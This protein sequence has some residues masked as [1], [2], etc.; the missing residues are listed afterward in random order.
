M[1]QIEPIPIPFNTSDPLILQT[2]ESFPNSISSSVYEIPIQESEI[3]IEWTYQSKDFWILSNYQIVGHILTIQEDLIDVFLL[4][5]NIQ[6]QQ[7]QHHSLF[8]QNIAKYSPNNLKM[9]LWDLRMMRYANHE[10]L[11]KYAKVFLP[12]PIFEMNDK[13]ST[14]NFEFNE[15]I[16]GNLASFIENVWN[17]HRRQNRIVWNPHR[18]NRI[19]SILNQILNGLQ[20]LHSSNIIHGNL[21]PQHIYYTENGNC[22]IGN[23]RF[24]RIKLDH[25][26][27]G[28]YFDEDDFMGGYAPIEMLI[29]PYYS[30][31]SC[32]MW[33]VGCILAEL[34]LETKFDSFHNIIELIGPPSEEDLNEIKKLFSKKEQKKVKFISNAEIMN[35]MLSEVALENYHNSSPLAVDLMKK[36]L[37]Y[38]PKKRITCE[39]AL[40]HKYFKEFKSGKEEFIPEL[41][42]NDF[43]FNELNWKYLRTNQINEMIYNE[44]LLINYPD[45]LKNYQNKIENGKK[46]LDIIFDRPPNHLK[47]T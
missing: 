12:K 46:S 47:F 22:I 6:S 20:Y 1:G 18:Q 41:P 45:K 4:N 29:N 26:I 30:D 31:S 43:D 33:S 11:L 38:D 8:H 14:L 13:I 9:L 5:E 37:V 15:K 32:D 7:L 21:D 2:N 28:I 42:L 34:L 25:K 27:Y 16:Q 40:N 10:N 19:R 44:M 24:S 17:P 39:E 35:I 3:Y 36:L 23:F